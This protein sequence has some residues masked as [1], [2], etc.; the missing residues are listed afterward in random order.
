MGTKIPNKQKKSRN[1]SELFTIITPANLLPVKGHKYLI[2]ACE[3][4]IKQNIKNIRFI[5]YGDGPGKQILGK[6]IKNRNLQKYIQMPGVINHKRLI[7]IYKNKKAN[8]VVIPSIN[9]QNNEH[10][11]I[12]VAL[13]EAMAH[14]IPVISTKTGGIPELLINRE[15][16]V[17]EKSS[18]ILA[19]AIIEIIKNNNLK[20]TIVKTNFQKVNNDFNVNKVTNELLELIE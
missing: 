17:K 13:I 1:Y 11:G 16:L 2:E 6:D 5:F 9:T 19:K 3:I 10:E 8:L 14:K 18:I 15:T 7:D 4:M 20:E 12:P